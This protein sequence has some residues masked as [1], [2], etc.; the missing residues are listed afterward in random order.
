MFNI[1]LNRTRL[2]LL[3]FV[4][5]IPEPKFFFFNN[6]VPI[7]MAKPLNCTSP[8]KTEYNIK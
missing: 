7:Q 1:A 2:L 4:S 8:P 6:T 5:L 3:K